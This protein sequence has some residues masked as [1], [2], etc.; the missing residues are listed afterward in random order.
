MGIDNLN[1]KS[2][3]I[4]LRDFSGQRAFNSSSFYVVSVVLMLDKIMEILSTGE[5]LK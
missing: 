2:I 1:V 3:Q 4:T 5:Q